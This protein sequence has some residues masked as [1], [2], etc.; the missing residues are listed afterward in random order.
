MPA[1]ASSTPAIQSVVLT[2]PFQAR[3]TYWNYYICSHDRAG[4]FSP[5][6]KISGTGTTFA[7]S[8][9]QLPNGDSAVLF[10]AADALPLRQLSPYRFQLSG[11]RQ[12]S[13]GGRDSI[14]LPWLPAAAASPV[15]P[16]TGEPLAGR[17][18]IYVYV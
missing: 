17:S 14:A 13:N 10:A 6:L 9:E 4:G 1:P 12:G 3:E 11:K 15:W 5:G 8:T 7:K 16:A 18:E 2:L